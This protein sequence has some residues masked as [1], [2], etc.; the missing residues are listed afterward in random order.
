MDLTTYHRK[1]IAD[2]GGILLILFISYLFFSGLYYNLYWTFSP[3][4]PIL[5]RTDWKGSKIETLLQKATDQG[6]AYQVQLFQIYSNNKEE[7]Y[8]AILQRTIWYADLQNAESAWGDTSKVNSQIYSENYHWPYSMNV[9]ASFSDESYIELP[10]NIS[11]ESSL[12]CDD[13]DDQ[14]I[15]AYFGHHEHWVT[16]IWFMS[17]DKSILTRELMYELISKAV[18]IILEA[19]PPAQ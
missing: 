15:C 16:H 13:Q 9:G 2:L 3:R 1:Y 6:Y 17:E 11:I 19:H 14:R 4:P 7:N 8:V 12:R 18:N 10:V 5:F